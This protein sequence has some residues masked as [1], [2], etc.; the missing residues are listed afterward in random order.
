MK[1]I[2]GIP[3]LREYAFPDLKERG[4]GTE[5]EHDG[6]SDLEIEKRDTRCVISVVEEPQS[7]SDRSRKPKKH[8]IKRTY[9][10][11]VNGKKFKVDHSFADLK[12]EQVMKDKTID[13]EKGI[14]IFTNTSF[15]AF[16]NTK[17]HVFYAAWHIAESIAEVMVERNQR[18]VEE[19][20]QIRDLIL[21]KSSELTR[22]LDEVEKENKAAERLRREL[23]ARMARAS[24]LEAK[25]ADLTS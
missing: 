7:T 13:D 10:V 4:K 22:Q 6:L 17:D 3:Q 21:K 14:Q 25:I 23:E 12:T 20:A 24:E 18:P 11:M 15:P 8:Q 5:D 9:F 16:A 2:K 19:V 1:A